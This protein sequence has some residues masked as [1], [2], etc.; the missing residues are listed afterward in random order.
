MECSFGNGG[1]CED[2]DDLAVCPN[3]SEGSTYRQHGPNVKCHADGQW[4]SVCD[5]TPVLSPLCVTKPCPKE[6]AHAKDI[7]YYT[8]Q[9]DVEYSPSQNY[10]DDD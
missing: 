10:I 6:V 9:H 7:K 2:G 4:K 5:E 3:D 8:S 1:R